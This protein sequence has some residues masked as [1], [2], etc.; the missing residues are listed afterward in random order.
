ML[1]K[2]ASQVRRADLEATRSGHPSQACALLSPH[3]P[4]ACHLLEAGTRFITLDWVR[5]RAPGGC[6]VVIIDPLMPKTRL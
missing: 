1:P 5:S 6:S 3:P 4:L 2:R